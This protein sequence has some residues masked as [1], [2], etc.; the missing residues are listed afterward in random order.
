LVSRA[1]FFVRETSSFEPSIASTER[2]T[3]SMHGKMTFLEARIASPG[4]VDDGD[5]TGAALFVTKDDDDARKDAI[6]VSID[7]LRRADGSN[8]V[9]S[10]SVIASTNDADGTRA[11]VLRYEDGR[12]GHEHRADAHFTSRDVGRHQ[13]P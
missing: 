13:S 8:D 6:F 4:A 10:E 3:A 5:V 12:L 9:R 1:T 11:A 2:G 7:V